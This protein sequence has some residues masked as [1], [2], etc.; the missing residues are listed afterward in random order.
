MV[1]FMQL[2][3]KFFLALEVHL[4]VLML[5]TEAGRSV[6]GIEKAILDYLL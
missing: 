1:N 6:T 5:P 3:I 4:C 2:D